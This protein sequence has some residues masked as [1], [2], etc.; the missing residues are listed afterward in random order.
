M[1]FGKSP[2]SAAR[3]GKSFVERATSKRVNTRD[4]KGVPQAE[5]D[6]QVLRTVDEELRRYAKYNGYVGIS[7]RG[8]NA[9]GYG[10]PG[11]LGFGKSDL[12]A[13][14]IY[15]PSIAG[16]N[17]HIDMH[18]LDR[19]MDSY[20]NRHFGEKPLQFLRLSFSLIA[21][22]ADGREIPLSERLMEVLDDPR[23]SIAMAMAFFCEDMIGPRIAE[24]RG[25]IA[26]AMATLPKQTQE[27]LLSAI[28]SLQVEFER[29]RTDT[30]KKRF[31]AEFDTD[32]K[33][34]NYFAKRKELWEKRVRKVFVV[35]TAPKNA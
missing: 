3:S 24:Y 23:G 25:A 5:R 30:L 26:E 2:E 6:I 7:Y 18:L 8:S 11:F 34:E 16:T 31:S 29:E 4:I 12:D 22:D 9:R 28:A 21:R 14:V 15:D 32:S 27:Q 13:G 20:R 19:Q 1:I 10:D 35:A 17:D 33:I